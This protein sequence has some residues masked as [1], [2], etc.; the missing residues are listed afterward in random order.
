MLV[1][2]IE[3]SG[4]SSKFHVVTKHGVFDMALSHTLRVKIWK[5]EGAT[6]ELSVAKE[7]AEAIV[8]RHDPNTE[9]RRLYI[10]AE[11][12]CLPTADETVKQIRKQGF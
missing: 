12:N 8:S 1:S 7:L 5:L 6:H 11:H 9:F 10:F 4:N 3:S 2:V